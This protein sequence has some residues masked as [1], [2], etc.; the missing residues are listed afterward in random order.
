V[1]NFFW[2]VERFPFESVV[3]VIGRHSCPEGHVHDEQF[4]GCGDNQGLPIKSILTMRI[5]TKITINTPMP[6]CLLDKIILPAFVL[7]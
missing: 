6:K 2:A 1:D 4:S 3:P 7:L 5:N